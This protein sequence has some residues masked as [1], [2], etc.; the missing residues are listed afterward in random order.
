MIIDV[1]ATKAK[2]T[3]TIAASPYA[4]TEEK[5]SRGPLIL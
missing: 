2:V 5:P 1:K 4:F 3:K